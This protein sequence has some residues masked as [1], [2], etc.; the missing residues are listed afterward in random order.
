MP[1]QWNPDYFAPASSESDEFDPVPTPISI[2]EESQDMKGKII[3][4][5][6]G[7]DVEHFL[8]D[9][10]GKPI[11][12]IDLIGGTKAE[13]R[14]ILGGNGFAIQ[15]DN[16]ALEY[17]IPP[18][19]DV[20]SFVYNLM[21]VQ[22]AILEEVKN[23]GLAPAIVPSMKFEA[24][25]LDH[26]Q[27]RRAGCEADY[28]VWDKRKNDPVELDAEW[29]AAG[30][31]LHTSFTVGGQVPTFPEYLTELE[32]LV[33]AYDICIGVPSMKVDK[34]LQRRKFYGK[35]GAFRPKVYGSQ[36]GLEYR[37]LSPW[38]TQQPKYMGWVFGQVEKAVRLVNS[39]GPNAHNKLTCYKE[40]VMKAINENDEKAQQ[41][42]IISF[43]TSI[44]AA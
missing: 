40:T 35:A 41:E 19:P 15:E 37:V 16:V 7:A 28:C 1:F 30:G 23:Y 3:L 11:P 29:R 5:K 10:Q 25:Q 43:N 31:H 6:V 4:D 42:I 12:C 2:Q 33:M 9:A 21:R 24:K 18:A 17:N 36:A 44:P 22:E 38:W 27:A 34:D 39:W 8:V 13:P 32:C 20:Y 26:P 14:P